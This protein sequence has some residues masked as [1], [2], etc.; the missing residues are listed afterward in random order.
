M[1]FQAEKVII[2]ASSPYRYK[3]ASGRVGI[4]TLVSLSRENVRVKCSAIMSVVVNMSLGLPLRLGI[5]QTLQ[6][7]IADAQ[8]SGRLTL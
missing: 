1:G 8:F 2:F 4:G 7:R 3:G 5:Q 6:G